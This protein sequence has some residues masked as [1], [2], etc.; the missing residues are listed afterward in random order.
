M[1]N[2]GEPAPV[3]DVCEASTDRPS[4][5]SDR[6]SRSARLAVVTFSVYLTI[7]F[8]VLVRLGRKY[9]FYSDDFG[10]LVRKWRSGDGLFR[11]QNGHWSTLPLLAYH[12]LYWAFG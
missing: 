5:S 7:A 4:G 8:F 2:I 6:T 1:Q 11:P 3:A 12:F 10:L 9:W